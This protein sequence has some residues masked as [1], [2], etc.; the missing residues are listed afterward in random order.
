[1]GSRRVGTTLLLQHVVSELLDAPRYEPCEVAYISLD[2]P[3]YTGLSSEEAAQETREA[4][5]NLRNPRVLV[6]D[7][8]Q[9][10]A[11]WERHLK[12]FVDSYPDVRC[13]VFGS[14]AA[15]LRLKSIESG[16]GRFTEFLLPPLT[17]Y[18]CLHLQGVDGL[19][20]HVTD[21]SYR[22]I[23]I[24]ESN[25]HFIEYLNFGDY[26]EIVSSPAVRSDFCRFLGSDI[27]DKVLLRDTPS[28]YGIQDTPELNSLFVSLAHTTA[29]EVSLEELSQ[30]SGVTKPTILAF[31]CPW[32]RNA[33]LFGHDEE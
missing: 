31:I 4:S 13:V 24:A 8:I 30:D 23:D 14:A 15:A 19:V 2:Q 18:E 3:L 7:E 12:V 33:S 26:L 27:V 17:Y 11:D 28:L 32:D 1:M 9:Y 10:L 29:G 20:E 6:L 22:L 5:G 21:S 25:R 16:A